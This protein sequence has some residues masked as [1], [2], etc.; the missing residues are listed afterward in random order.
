MS[1]LTNY[2]SEVKA[3]L[4]IGCHRGSFADY[5]NA[6]YRPNRTWCIDLNPI[7]QEEIENKGYVFTEAAL[8]GEDREV[9]PVYF[10]KTDSYSTGN[11]LFRENTRHF[12]DENL[13]VVEK[14]TMTLDTLKDIIFPNPNVIF[15]FIKIDAQGGEFD[16]I[17]GGKKV[18]K[19]SN[20]VLAETSLGDYNEG[21][22]KQSHTISI[23]R[24]YG[25]EKIAVIEDHYHQNELIQQDILFKKV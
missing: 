23:M 7:F 6:V 12:S 16:I 19:N 22:T 25:F 21:A 24:Y 14:E 4:D 9:R 8:A 10:N 15:D 2:I 3:F 11:S 13:K 20:F 18:I 5:I 17:M 1:Q